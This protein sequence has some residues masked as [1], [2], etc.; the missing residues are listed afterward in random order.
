MEDLERSLWESGVPGGCL[1]NARGALGVLWE[2]LEGTLDTLGGA[3]GPLN[4]AVILG[5]PWGGPVGSPNRLVMS[6]KGFDDV[7]EGSLG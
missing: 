1:G 6:T 2:S 7:S 4:V 5:R 3:G